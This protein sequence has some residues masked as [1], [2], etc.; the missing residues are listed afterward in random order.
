MNAEWIVHEGREELLLFFNGW[1]MDRRVADYLRSANSAAQDR[2]IAV[3]YDYG[4][5]DIP[6]WLKS[7]MPRY[8][9]IDILAWSLGVWAS[10]HAGLEGV[11][12]AVAINGTPFPVDAELGISPKVFRDTIESW[13]G[14]SRE[15]FE[16]RM[17]SGSREVGIDAVRSARRVQ[18]QQ[19]ELRAIE[20]AVFR[21]AGE[22][23]PS[24]SFSKAI[25]G[26]RDLVFLPGNQRRAWQDVPVVEIAKMPHFPFFNIP[27]FR[28]AFE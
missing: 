8:K 11:R 21:L 12:H 23:P 6:G 9:A 4:D 15:R 19:S 27:G 17:F 10:M 13:S 28:E 24:W 5:L 25:V 22:P 20:A 16:R 26:G 2:D 3:L 7:G 14:E 18:D 1:G